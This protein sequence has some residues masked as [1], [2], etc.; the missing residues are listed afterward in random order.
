MTVAQTATAFQLVTASANAHSTSTG[1][2]SSSPSALGN[3]KSGNGSSSSGIGQGTVIGI[4]VGAVTF[5]VLAGA[6]GLA[7]FCVRKR[8]SGR[9]PPQQ[10]LIDL[11]T[12]STQALHGPEYFGKVES[13]P[14]TPTPQTPG[15]KQWDAAPPYPQ[16]EHWKPYQVP[17]TGQGGQVLFELE[18]PVSRPTGKD[19]TNVHELA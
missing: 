8:N 13:Y 18:N 11:Q 3:S 1:T 14:M 15:A 5:L 16:N 4:V 19:G 12:P 6:A 10:N 17:P 9:P 2:S 7:W